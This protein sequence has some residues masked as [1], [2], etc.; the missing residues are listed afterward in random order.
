M[1]SDDAVLLQDGRYEQ[2][3]QVDRRRLEAMITG[4]PLDY[5]SFI[6][7]NAED[8]FDKVKQ[9]SGADVC[10]PSHLKIGAKTKK[11]PFV[12]V[13]GTMNEIERAKSYINGALRVKKDRV[14]LKMDIH[15]S[16]HSHII[17]KAG[18]GIQ[19]VM[20]A[21]GCHIHFPDSN[22]YTDSTNKSDQVSISGSPLN[23]EKALKY[24]RAISPVI[25]S[26]ELPWIFPKEP[27]ITALP[28]EVGLTLRAVTPTVYSCVLKSN[29]GDEFI[30]LRT[31]S[32]ITKCFNIP[33]EF[34][35]AIC[36]TFSVK[37]DLLPVLRTGQES[38]RL[39]RLAHH[40]GVQLH[41]P[42][43]SQPLLISGPSNGVL[44]LRKF[45]VGLSSVVLSFD[46]PLSEFQM[47]IEPIQKEYGV[48]IY[49]KKKNN[50][51]DTL[52]ISIKSK[53]EN[54]V[55]VLRAREFLLGTPPR[56]MRMTTMAKNQFKMNWLPLCVRCSMRIQKLRK[57][58]IP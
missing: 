50:A 58:Q 15:H 22:K 30:L 21:T 45:I 43:Q 29:A 51:H 35:I 7:L 55:N 28:P 41:V 53:E 4:V 2:K 12:K 32:V 44:L 38:Q 16:I 27:E 23:I 6:F 56:I 47:D 36:T 17:G 10:W 34:P 19:Q 39:L 26:F 24:L 1:V 54:I 18:R 5:A 3:I 13:I 40:Y 37:D 49:S 48:S 14:T 20:R 31:I 57:V 11:D 46:V 9:Y 42:D 52:V 33:E 25:I 8:F